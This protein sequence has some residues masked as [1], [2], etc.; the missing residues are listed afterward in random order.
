MH[1]STVI[2]VEFQL[3]KVESLHLSKHV[4][5]CFDARIHAVPHTTLGIR[6]TP[7][8]VVEVF[9]TVAQLAVDALISGRSLHGTARIVSK[10]VVDRVVDVGHEATNVVEVLRDIV[11]TVDVVLVVVHLVVA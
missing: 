3:F 5:A 8:A 4:V 9:N 2:G 6:G 10:V 7:C 1:L 11:F